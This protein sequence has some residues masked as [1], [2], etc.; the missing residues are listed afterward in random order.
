MRVIIQM[1]KLSH[2]IMQLLMKETP[3]IFEVRDLLC[4][5]MG[6]AQK[7]LK[8]IVPFIFNIFD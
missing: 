2:V 5:W 1:V 6:M 7:P 3:V 8:L 4:I